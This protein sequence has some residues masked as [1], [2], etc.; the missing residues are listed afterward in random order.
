MKGTLG[1][2][3]FEKAYRLRLPNFQAVKGARRLGLQPRSTDRD[4][5]K[6]SREK[7]RLG[8]KKEDELNK[9]CFKDNT[10]R[11]Q[12]YEHFEGNVSRALNVSK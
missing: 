7:K 4:F 2:V 3:L 6:Q 10:P 12:R 1:V 9:T 5:L 8:Q 11:A